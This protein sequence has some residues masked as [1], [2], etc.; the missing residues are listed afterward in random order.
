MSSS[1]VTGSL[2]KGGPTTQEGKEVVEMERHPT[3]HTLSGTS[4]PRSGEE[5]GLGRAQRRHA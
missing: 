5:R 3:R 4:C 2:V 1:S